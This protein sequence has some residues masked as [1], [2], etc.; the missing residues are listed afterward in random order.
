MKN[1]KSLFGII[2]FLA[3]VIVVIILGLFLHKDKNEVTAENFKVEQGDGVFYLNGGY[4]ILKTKDECVYHGG[5]SAYAYDAYTYIYNK[6]TKALYIFVAGNVEDMKYG[7]NEKELLEKLEE[8][9]KITP[10]KQDDL[11]TKSG[12]WKHVKMKDFVDFKEDVCD[13]DSYYQFKDNKIYMT[14]IYSDA[15]SKKETHILDQLTLKDKAIVV[16]KNESPVKI[17]DDGSG[18]YEKVMEDTEYKMYFP[19][20]IAKNAF[21]QEQ[22]QYVEFTTED[23]SIITCRGTKVKEKIKGYYKEEFKVENEETIEYGSLKNKKEQFVEYEYCVRKMYEN[24]Y[25]YLARVQI[26]N[27]EDYYILDINSM[28][29]IENMEL[30]LKDFC[31]E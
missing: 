15:E 19:E 5:D 9:Y 18:S 27:G 22:E 8:E 14:I 25:S 31:I 7:A 20:E 11:K 16:Y 6:T 17:E 23:G 24:T 29:P 3:V 2:G 4:M 30:Y 28:K 1:K 13:V 10:K 21:F 26:H 12:T